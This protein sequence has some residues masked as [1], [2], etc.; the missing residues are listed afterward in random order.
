VSTFLVVG[1][2]VSIPGTVLLIVSLGLFTGIS[3][4]LLLW[5]F[6]IAWLFKKREEDPAW[7]GRSSSESE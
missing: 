4:V 3:A 2:I 6:A 1:G 5:T 7:G